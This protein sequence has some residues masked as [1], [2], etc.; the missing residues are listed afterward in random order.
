MPVLSQGGT[1]ER[2]FAGESESAS[3]SNLV[4]MPPGA[5]S[6]AFCGAIA[7]C[8]WPVSSHAA[9][10]EQFTYLRLPEMLWRGNATPRSLS[11]P[12]RE[13]DDVHFDVIP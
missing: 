2:A 8:W 4:E 3:M 7:A 13:W 10:V 1:I 12:C 6:C 5:V 9:A 11:L